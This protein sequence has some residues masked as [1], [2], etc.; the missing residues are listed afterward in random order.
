M[1]RTVRYVLVAIAVILLALGLL[2]GGF[3]ALSS[4]LPASVAGSGPRLLW[5][6]SYSS[7]NRPDNTSGSAR[8]QYLLFDGRERNTLS[9]NAGQT[10]TF[11]YKANVNYGELMFRFEKPNGKVAWEKI[12]SASVADSA[13]VPVAESGLHA[14]IV[15]GLR[16][17]GGYEISWRA[18]SN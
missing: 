1:Y 17:G 4:Y 13:R 2:G 10:V 18:T 8:Y 14:L 3:Y 12:L 5:A 11:E 9:L 7:T 15:R 16:T 6:G